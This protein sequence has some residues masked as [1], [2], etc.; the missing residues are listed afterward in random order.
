MTRI[1]VVD[2]EASIRELFRAVLEGECFDALLLGALDQGKEVIDVAVYISI[3]QKTDEVQGP[4]LSTPV[5]HLFPN[6]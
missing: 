5:D 6:P 4:A 2:D 3:A 1:L